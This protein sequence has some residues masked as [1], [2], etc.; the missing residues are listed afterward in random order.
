MDFDPKWI[1]IHNGFL[2]Q[3]GL[4]TPDI[5]NIL[6]KMDFWWSIFFII[7]QNCLNTLYWIKN[8]LHDSFPENPRKTVWMKEDWLLNCVLLLK[9]S[10]SYQIALLTTKT[11]GNFQEIF[12]FA[13]LLSCLVLW[14]SVIFIIIREISVST[15]F[16]FNC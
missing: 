10:K 15:L 3:I 11:F 5:Q 2:V 7:S 13:S 4:L 9:D 6:T 16:N 14:S 12:S 8:L 1:L